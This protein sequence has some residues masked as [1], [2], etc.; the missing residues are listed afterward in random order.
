MAEKMSIKEDF[1]VRKRML[2][3]ADLKCS[4]LNA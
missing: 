3:L 1:G 4:L 2:N